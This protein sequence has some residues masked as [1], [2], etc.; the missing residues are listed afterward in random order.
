MPDMVKFLSGLRRF[1][2]GIGLLVSWGIGSGGNAAVA[3]ASEPAGKEI[4]RRHCVDCHG[5]HGEGVA[6]EYDSP[7]QGDKSIEKLTRLIDKYMPDDDPG[8][9]VGPDAEAVARFIYD[10]FYS[11]AAQARTQ[12]PR[13]ELAHLTN[14]QFQNAVADLIGH[15]TGGVAGISGGKGLAAI[16]YKSRRLRRA[17][18]VLRRTDQRIDFDFGEGVPKN[19]G[20]EAEAEEGGEKDGMEEEEFSIRWHGSVIAPETGEYE[21]MVDSPNGFRLWVNDTDTPLI[22]GWV[23]SGD[24]KTLQAKLPLLGGRAYPI[25]LEIFKYKDKRAAITLRW[26]EPHGVPEII[27]ARHLSPE[28]SASTLVVSTPFPP[29]DSSVGYARGVAISKAWDQATTHAAI[30]VAHY[31]AEH[32]DQLSNTRPNDPK[33]EAKIMAFSREFVTTAFR[34]PL[35]KTQKVTY[36]D[37]HFEATDKL[38]DAVKRV[39]LLTIKSPRFLYL[40]LGGN[41][42]DGFTVAERLAFGLWDSLPDGDLMQAAG[43]DGLRTREQVVRM[44]RGMLGDPRSRAK[45][46]DFFYHWLQLDHSEDLSKDAEIFPEFTPEIIADLRTSLALFLEEVVWGPESD[47]RNLLLAD[48]L[49]LN[50]RLARFYGVDGPSKEAFAKVPF[51]PD[52]RSGVLT[53]PY[54]L[55]AFSYPKS[56]SPIHRGVFLTRNIVGRALNPPPKAVSFNDAEFEPGLTMREKVAELTRPDACQTCHSI[57]NPLGFSLEHYDAVG[58][59]RT[60]ERDRPIDSTSDYIAKDGQTIALT[61]A[62]DVAQYAAASEPGQKA[63]IEQL[64]HQVTKQPVLAYG[65]GVMHELHQSFVASHFNIRELMIKIATVAAMHGMEEPGLAEKSS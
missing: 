49:Y 50:D 1:Q 52:R 63:F 9:C 41:R 4:Y 45:M 10:A 22:D 8:Q 28:S 59:F 26:K 23:A 27:P 37:A 29:D 58:R 42:P 31:V 2:I 60:H 47:Y 48:Y 17:D 30:E 40:G 53:H 38:E 65:P 11:P 55:A 18:E 56:T 24:R 6:E 51:N 25:R 54:L 57:I 64:F 16:Y 34:R 21:F 5:P 35:T 7:L 33:R 61:G 43:N 39:V 14:R 62:R 32:I 15:F 3:A 20:M 19:E 12:K 44:A 46:Q 13:I 36:V